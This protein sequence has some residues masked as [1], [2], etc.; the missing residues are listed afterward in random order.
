M[1]WARFF[2]QHPIAGGL[3]DEALRI[4]SGAEDGMEA[5]AVCRAL[6]RLESG[7]LEDLEEVCDHLAAV[8]AASNKR[9]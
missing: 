4:L 2:E 3:A 5:M 6:D 1:R 7:E 8:V 9:R